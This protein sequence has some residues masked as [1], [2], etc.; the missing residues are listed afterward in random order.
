MLG[1]SV[2]LE[3]Q[4]VIA[5]SLNY[6]KGRYNVL[7]D[8]LNEID[9]SILRELAER[10]AEMIENLSLTTILSVFLQL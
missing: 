2:E 3:R 8:R 5:L 10:D 9:R 6:N 1:S 4:L 7:S